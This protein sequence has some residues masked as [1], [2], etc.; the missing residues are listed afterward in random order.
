MDLAGLGTFRAVAAA[1]FPELSAARAPQ[2]LVEDA[3]AP[4]HLGGR[5]G[6]GFYDYPPGAHEQWITR[7]DERLLALRRTLAP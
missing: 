1:L 6:K 7:R 2:K 3:I 5:A 4:G